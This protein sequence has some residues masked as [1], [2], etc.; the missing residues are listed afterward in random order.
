MHYWWMH[1]SSNKFDIGNRKANGVVCNRSGSSKHSHTNEHTTLASITFVFSIHSFIPSYCMYSIFP[2]LEQ[3]FWSS[4][5]LQSWHS[6]PICL[7]CPRPVKFLFL[8]LFCQDSWK[9]YNN[10]T[11]HLP[12]QLFFFF[13][14]ILTFSVTS[15]YISF[16]VLRKMN[17]FGQIACNENRHVISGRC[18][19]GIKLNVLPPSTIPGLQRIPG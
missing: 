6:T 12:A 5:I 7:H 4:I 19:W 13:L 15:T 3:I 11:D 18:G 14:I 1:S 9:C 10:L 16:T 2:S 8:F 17:N